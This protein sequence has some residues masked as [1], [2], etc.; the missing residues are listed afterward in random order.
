[1]NKKQAEAIAA[2]K[3]AEGFIA[4]VR[5][6]GSGRWMVW[7]MA[8]GFNHLTSRITTTKENDR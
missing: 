3:R 5:N 1:M 2:E 4:E 7:V 8:S 6:E